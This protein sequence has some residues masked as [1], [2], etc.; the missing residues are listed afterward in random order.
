ML[1]INRIFGTVHLRFIDACIKSEAAKQEVIKMMP[2]H[3]LYFMARLI[4]LVFYPSYIPVGKFYPVLDD[5]LSIKTEYD[6]SPI[7]HLD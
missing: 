1:I 4:I 7:L 6:I 5:F 2:L 3:F